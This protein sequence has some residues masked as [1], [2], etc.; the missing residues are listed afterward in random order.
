MSGVPPP[1]FQPPSGHVFPHSTQSSRRVDIQCKTNNAQI[2]YTTDCTDPDEVCIVTHTEHPLSGRTSC[3]SIIVINKGRE[4]RSVISLCAGAPSVRR[5]RVW[6]HGSPCA[7]HNDNQGHCRCARREH[8]RRLGR[9]PSRGC[10]VFCGS[11]TPAHYAVRSSVVLG[12]RRV[13]SSGPEQGVFPVG[14]VADSRQASWRVE[15]QAHWRGRF[16]LCRCHQRWR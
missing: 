4:S 16:P 9:L 13:G 10:L 1:T 15:N 3:S 8:P 7:N 11:N 12:L 5:H 14:A 2:R 6:W